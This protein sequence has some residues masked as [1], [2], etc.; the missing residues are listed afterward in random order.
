MRRWPGIAGAVAATTA[1]GVAT[2]R[3]LMGWLRAQL[4]PEV[5][6]AFHESRG[7]QLAMTTDDGVP[8]YVDVDGDE[9]SPLTIVFCHGWALQSASWYYQRRGL[10]DLGRLVFW[11]QR[12]HGRSGRGHRARNTIE[13]SGH[14]LRSVLDAVAPTGPLMLVG[15]SMGG[16]TIMALAEQYPRFFNTRV[17][18]A[19]LLNT[20]AGGLAEVFTGSLG[21]AVHKL[22]SPLFR[23]MGRAAAPV[24]RVRSLSRLPRHV[25]THRFAFGTYDVPPESVAFMD[26]MLSATPVDVVADYYSAIMVHDRLAALEAFRGVPVLVLAGTEDRVIPSGFSRTIAEFVPEAELVEISGAGHMVMLECPE[27]VNQVLRRFA[28]RCLAEGSG[29]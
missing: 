19:V 28:G 9:A 27:R 8:L 22:A 18:G 17:A 20:S 21:A 13:V 4:D 16:M 2:E 23:G 1:A 3:Y 14:D 5:L 15:H 26:S 10:D 24:E 11:D 29:S 25:L 7:R 6:R 12:S